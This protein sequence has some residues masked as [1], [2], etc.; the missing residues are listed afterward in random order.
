[1]MDRGNK[2]AHITLT[3]TL[4]DYVREIIIEYFFIYG[5]PPWRL[6]EII[7]YQNKNHDSMI[8]Y[9]DIMNLICMI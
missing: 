9:C 3:C 7:L 1:M 6:R 5:E 8:C 2:C 4:N